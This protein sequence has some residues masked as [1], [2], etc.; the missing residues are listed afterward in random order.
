MQLVSISS[1]FSSQKMK[2][3]VEQFFKTNPTPS[4]NRTIL[5]SIEKIHLNSVW[6]DKN[7]ENLQNFLKI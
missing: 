4:A 3:D 2:N 7:R 1:V 6:L 5:Q